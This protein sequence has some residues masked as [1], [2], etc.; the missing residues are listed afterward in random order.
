METYSSK[1]DRIDGNSRL[2]KYRQVINT[3]LEEINQELFKP[4]DRIPS[5]N[6]TSE[7]YYLSRDTVE[8]AYKEL[9]LR[10]IISSI[11]GKGF[12]VNGNLEIAKLKVLVIF[13]KLTTHNKVIYNALVKT[14]GNKASV[15][16]NVH[17]YD[18]KYF[19]DT[20]LDNLGTYDYYVVMPHFYDFRYDVCQILKKVPANKLLILDKKPKALTNNYACVYQDYSKDLEKALFSAL[21]LLQKYRKI[22]LVYPKSIQYPREIRVGFRNFCHDADIDYDLISSTENIIPQK[23]EAFLIMEEPDIINMIKKGRKQKLEIGKDLG[24]IS[25]NDNP[26][27]EIVENGIT[28]LTTDHFK[29]G[30]TAADMILHKKRQKVK[31][32]FYLVRR[33][34]L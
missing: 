2:P 27:N 18:F 30:Q 26:M 32:P 21:D 10:G 19:E 13:D 23:G 22:Y 17:Q 24:I 25:Y 3:I 34:S 29:M 16:F 1:I 8:K 9:S 7:E 5:I 15:N 33:N 4:G 11:P 31:N 14:L 12:Y 28:A 20:V 6:E